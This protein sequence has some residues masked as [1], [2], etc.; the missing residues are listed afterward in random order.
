MPSA[1][2]KIRD[3]AP[4]ITTFSTPFN[5]FAPFGYRRFVAVGNRA[6]A[7]RLHDNRILLL[8]PIQLE[9]AVRD[10]LDR[11]GGVHLIASDLGH[12]MYVKD[13][14]DAWPEAKTIGVPG[15]DSMRKDVNWNYIYKDWRTSPEDQ[16]DFAQDFET[17]LF[18]G[19]ITYCV[20]WYHKPTK[21]LIQSDLMMNLPCTE[22]YHPSSSDQGPLSREFAKRAHPR[23]IWAKRLVYYIATVD[24]TLMRR[25]AKKVAEW[26]I[27]RII[28]CHGDVLESGG[29]E[30]WS[31]VYGWFLKGTAKP[32]VMKRLMN[33]IMKFAR[34]VFLM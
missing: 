21:T 32:S 27:D 5:R 16:F 23:S 28:P 18:E 4:T 19:F 31:S 11:L 3:I 34:K 13:Y 9:D 15:L 14:V 7:I 33:P 24:Y 12:H 26:Q 10:K 22:Q 29:N 2:L 6:T 1:G 20:A 8:N 25:D 17:V 30:A